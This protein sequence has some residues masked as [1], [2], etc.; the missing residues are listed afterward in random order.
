MKIARATMTNETVPQTRSAVAGSMREC[1]EAEAG[2]EAQKTEGLGKGDRQE[3]V[4]AQV[5]LE[6][7]LARRRFLIL[8]ADE[9]DADA[10]AEGRETVT[11]GG[12]V[13]DHFEFLLF[14][15]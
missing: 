15:G 3:H 6:L 12:D 8:R 7:G 2:H 11:D 9:S 10:G 1:S 14:G 13:A 5:S 4:D